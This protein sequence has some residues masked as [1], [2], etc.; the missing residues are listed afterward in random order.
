[1]NYFTNINIRKFLFTN[2]DEYQRDKGNT[3]QSKKVYGGC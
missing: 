2:D 1:M 3:E